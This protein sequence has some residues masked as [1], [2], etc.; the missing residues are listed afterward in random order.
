MVPAGIVNGARRSR[1]SGSTTSTGNRSGFGAAALGAPLSQHE[2]RS[3]A[4]YKSQVDAY[5]DK[6]EE[7]LR[8]AL[9]YRTMVAG[10]GALRLELVNATDRYHPSLERSRPHRVQQVR[11]RVVPHN[12]HDVCRLDVAR[13]SRSVWAKTSKAGA[14]VLRTNEQLHAGHARC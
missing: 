14:S 13:S 10:H 3:T 2:G 4:Q 8:E 5:L 7:R 1:I 9:L 12:G 6:C 11:A